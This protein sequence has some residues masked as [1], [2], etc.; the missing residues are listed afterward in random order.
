[1]VSPCYFSF[2][3]R[4]VSTWLVTYYCTVLLVQC[5]GPTTF[6]CKS[7]N[8]DG[9]DWYIFYVIVVFSFPG[10]TLHPSLCIPGL[11]FS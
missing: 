5:E 3:A 6:A 7:K 4:K 10:L 1:M 9:Q 8:A 11:R 2:F